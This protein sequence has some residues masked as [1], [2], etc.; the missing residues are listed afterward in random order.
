MK[1]DLLICI[2]H[3]YSED[4]IMYLKR[5]ISSFIGTYL[6]N[7]DI[8]IDTNINKLLGFEK[9]SNVKVISHENLDHSFYLTWQHRAHFKKN[10]DNYE[11][12]MYLEDDMYLP[13]QNY[14]NYLTSFKVL[15]PKFVPSFVRIEEFQGK[16][17]ITDCIKTQELNVF[18]INGKQFTTLSNPYHAFW[19][20]PANEL[21]ETMIDTFV[22]VDQSRE[23]AASYPMWELFKKPLVELEHVN[24]KF[25]ISKKCY[26]YH[27]ANNY[28]T[29]K[30]SPH[31]KI[32][33]KNIFSC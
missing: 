25:E 23:H 29:C 6:I 4:R 31:A 5:L 17:F 32:E 14:Q 18:N 27:L 3:H 9:L 12:F 28:A 8:I 30:E 13:F 2:S 24:G 26:S 33:P 21:R 20:M 22:R 11:N 16:E 7:F 15:W 1:K 19:I 10:I